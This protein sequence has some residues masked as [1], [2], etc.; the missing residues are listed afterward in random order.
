MK[1]IILFDLDGTLAESG[2]KIDDEMLLILFEIKKKGYELGIVGGGKIDKILLQIRD[3]IFDHIF[4]ECGSVYFKW[5][6]HKYKEIYKKNLK[7]HDTYPEINTIIKESL[8][9][10]SHVDYTLSGH[11]IDRRD[12][13]IYISLIGMQATQEERLYYMELDKKHHYRK[14]LLKRLI[15]K[16]EEL[17]VSD[18][19]DIREGGSV[20]IGLYPKEWNKTQVL[21]VLNGYEEI[22]YFGDKYEEGGNDFELITHPN[23]KG[24]PVNSPEDTKNFLRNL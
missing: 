8:N 3:F 19:L 21:D 5:D 11:F 13:L 14:N 22:S 9:F 16:A 20:G 1:K 10:L 12:G 18:K 7:E 24:F 4:S 15:H 23:V 17:N 6:H 2:N